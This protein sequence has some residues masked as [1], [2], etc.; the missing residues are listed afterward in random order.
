MYD[1]V[2]MRKLQAFASLLKNVEHLRHW[3]LTASVNEIGESAPDK[4]IH[5]Q[6]WR[7]IAGDA[8][9]VNLYDRR[10]LQTSNRTRFLLQ[11]PDCGGIQSVMRQNYFQCHLTLEKQIGGTIYDAHS[12]LTK[13]LVD[14]VSVCQK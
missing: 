8:Q 13:A 2:G 14:S 12:S 10:M 9:I 3:Q 1:P 4:K 5:D 7:T 11:T 6:K